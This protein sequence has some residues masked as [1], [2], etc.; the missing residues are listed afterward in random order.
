MFHEELLSEPGGFRRTGFSPLRAALRRLVTTS[1]E[2]PRVVALREI[3]T[4][5]GVSSS[6]KTG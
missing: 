5:A 2:R 4:Q 1:L 3:W 6:L